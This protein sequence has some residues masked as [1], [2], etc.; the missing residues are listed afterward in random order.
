[1]DTFWTCFTEFVTTTISILA[2]AGIAY[3]TYRFQEK[4]STNSQIRIQELNKNTV[5]ELFQAAIS[6]LIFFLPTGE[7]D[8]SKQNLDLYSKKIKMIGLSL[9]A[10]RDIDLP[11]EF[12][13][14]FQYHRYLISDVQISVEHIIQ[15]TLSNP[16]SKNAFQNLDIEQVITDLSNFVNKYK[17]EPG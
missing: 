17:K 8:F 15:N 7:L 10:M 13:S 14:M 4:K 12:V 1:M 5:L 16:L 2:S 9:A 6:N 3:F 11:D